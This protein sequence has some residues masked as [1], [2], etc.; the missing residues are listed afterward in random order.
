MTL[1]FERKSSLGSA[2]ELVSPFHMA[3]RTKVVVAGHE[4]QQ[5]QYGSR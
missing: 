4:I 3:E 5:D 1:V 2:R